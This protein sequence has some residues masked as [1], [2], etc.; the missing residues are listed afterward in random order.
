MSKKH[1]KNELCGHS[2]QKY[3]KKI[4]R[5]GQKLVP[6]WL[7]SQLTTLRNDIE[8][9]NWTFLEFSHFRLPTGVEIFE[10]SRKTWPQ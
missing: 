9:K 3:P 4:V 10:K 5:F 6:F 8:T 1:I 2:D 7:L